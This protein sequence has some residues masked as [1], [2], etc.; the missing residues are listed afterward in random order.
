MKWQTENKLLTMFSVSSLTDIIFLL[1]IFF[2]L[3]SSIVIQPG[4]KVQ[5][6]SAEQ[7]PQQTE[8]NIVLTITEKGQYYVNNLLVPKGRL[9]STLAQQLGNDKERL[10]VINADKT[11]SLQLA[12]EVMDIAKHI[13]A[14]RFLIATAQEK[15]TKPR[16]R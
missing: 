9:E 7:T 10:I 13:G 8:Q 15:P 11:V 1:M 16:K 4:I 12:V 5:L 6:P 14:S 2:L 3:S